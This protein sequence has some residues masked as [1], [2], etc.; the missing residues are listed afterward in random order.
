M[1]LPNTN[2]AAEYFVLSAL[3]RLGIE[4]YLTIANKKGCDI[5]AIRDDQTTVRVEVKGIAGPYDWRA[6][7]LDVHATANRCLVLVGFENEISDPMRSPEIWVLPFDTLSPFVRKYANN[8]INISRAAIKASGQKYKN[9]W[10]YIS[11]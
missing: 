10:N 2:L 4:A 8:S 9:A 5:V 7:N 3:H 6:G 1:G 11:G